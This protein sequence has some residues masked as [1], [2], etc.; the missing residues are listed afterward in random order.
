M[1]FNI[2]FSF[3][4]SGDCQRIFLLLA[5]MCLFLNGSIMSPY[6][7][8]ISFVLADS[9][10]NKDNKDNEVSSNSN[11][12]EKSSEKNSDNEDNGR[13]EEHTSELQ[14]QSNLVCRL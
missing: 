6:S 13:S 2:S 14:S 10:D 3:I 5:C 12:H 4:Y 7:T 8:F 1:I 9:E 11:K